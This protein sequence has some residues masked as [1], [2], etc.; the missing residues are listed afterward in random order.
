MVEWYE[1]DHGG[2]LLSV[3]LQRETVETH[4]VGPSDEGPGWPR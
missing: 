2:F 4:C 3:Q 1:Q